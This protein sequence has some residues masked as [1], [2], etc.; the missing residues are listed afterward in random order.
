MVST[1]TIGLLPP[2]SAFAIPQKKSEM[3]SSISARKNIR[4]FKKSQRP[5]KKLTTVLEKLKLGARQSKREC[6]E[7]TLVQQCSAPKTPNINNLEFRYHSIPNVNDSLIS[8]L[9]IDTFGSMFGS[10]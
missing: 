3:K 9:S 1:S 2:S 5:T 6:F 4:K 7:R 8:E 10:I